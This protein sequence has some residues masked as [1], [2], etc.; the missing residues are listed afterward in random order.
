VSVLLSVSIHLKS[1]PKNPYLKYF[2]VD[3][4]QSLGIFTTFFWQLNP[5]LSTRQ[6]ISDTYRLTCILAAY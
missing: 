3:K 6:I 1:V 2:V 5:V 4:V